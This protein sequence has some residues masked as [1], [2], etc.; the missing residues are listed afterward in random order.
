MRFSELFEQD[1]SEG[2]LIP[3][4]G[5]TLRVMGFSFETYQITKMFANPNLAHRIDFEYRFEAEPGETPGANPKDII[6]VFADQQSFEEAKRVLNH[7]G[8]DYAEDDENRRSIGPRYISDLTPPDENDEYL[9][10]QP[11][12]AGFGEF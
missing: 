1:I 9:A 6:F 4:P 5:F 7:F 11:D 3:L 12:T 10:N 8:I 2:D